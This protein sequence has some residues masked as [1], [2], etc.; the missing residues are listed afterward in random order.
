MSVSAVYSDGICHGLPVIPHNQSGL[1]AI[2][3]GASGMSGQSTID[4]LVQNPK[5]WQRVYALSRRPPIV[6]SKN[7]AN[8]EHIRTD[9][10][11]SPE[12]I[13]NSLMERGVRA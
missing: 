1:H 3:V 7:Q 10:L 12:T 5:R 8:C 13:G 2:V 11:D 9:L 4:V 6:D